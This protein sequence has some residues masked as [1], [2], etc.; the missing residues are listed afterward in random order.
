M[1]EERLLLVLV[2]VVLL[3]VD[4]VFLTEVAD[5]IDGFGLF[6]ITKFGSSCIFSEQNGT[7]Q[8]SQPSQ[9]SEKE[10]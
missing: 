7:S 10:T 6:S 8:F 3:V 1:V 4:R 2:C 9:L 5:E